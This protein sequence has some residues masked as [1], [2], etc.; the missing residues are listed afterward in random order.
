MHQQSEYQR[1]PNDPMVNANISGFQW[2]NK[3]T[4]FKR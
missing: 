3:L 1:T 4:I 2:M